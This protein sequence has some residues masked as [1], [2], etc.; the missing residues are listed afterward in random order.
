MDIVMIGLIIPFLGTL[1][2]SGC[3]Y[4][5]KEDL[6]EKLQKALL[7]FAGGVMMGASVFSLL[8]PSLEHSEHL[9][10][11]SFVPTVI[12]F[13]IGMLF[14]WGLDM[15][16]PHMHTVSKMQEGMKSNFTRAIMMVL[17]MTLHNIPE[18]MAVGI[19]FVGALNGQSILMSEAL[20]L[21]IGIAI[22]NL[23]EGAIVSL[24]L[25]KEGLSKQKAFLWGAMSGVAELLACIFTIFITQNVD[26]AM[27]Y[28]LSFAAGAMVY[29]VVEELIPEANN[30][31][32][33][34]IMSLVFG[35]G[36]MILVIL[37]SILG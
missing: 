5:L 28:L 14:I 18:G 29:V 21:S 33:S 7:A 8:L 23:P 4:L 20:V 25:R 22:Q 10:V 1:L 9:N 6:N 3:V 16:I 12:G 35:L 13:A 15:I 27:P 34:N 36:F 11:F 19:L 31:E 24:P 32:H 17:A 30:G 26:G 37:K 2:G